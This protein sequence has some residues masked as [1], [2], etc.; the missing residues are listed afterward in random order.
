MRTVDVLPVPL[1][2]KLAVRRKTRTTSLGSASDLVGSQ[3]I[4]P[5]P[6]ALLGPTR[7]ESLYLNLKTQIHS[8]T[9]LPAEHV[10]IP[11]PLVDG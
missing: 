5:R 9:K 7:V 6:G 3:G 11:H 8:Q 4:T 1:G 10:K 2:Q